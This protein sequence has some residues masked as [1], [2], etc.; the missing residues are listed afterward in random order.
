MW[1]APFWGGGM[2][3]GAGGFDRSAGRVLR[4]KMPPAQL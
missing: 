4:K 3:L 1:M 2:A